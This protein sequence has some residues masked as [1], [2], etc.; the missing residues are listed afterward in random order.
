MR[1]IVIVQ[2]YAEEPDS[3]APLEFLEAAD[4]LMAE[5]NIHFPQTVLD[6]IDVH[7]TVVSLMESEIDN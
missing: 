3:P 5:N 2:N 4:A 1:D 7:N 6:A